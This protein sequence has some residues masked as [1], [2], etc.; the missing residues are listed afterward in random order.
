MVAEQLASQNTQIPRDEYEGDQAPESHEGEQINWTNYYDD[1][2]AE[3]WKYGTTSSG[4]QFQ[5]SQA[6]GFTRYQ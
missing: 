3:F 4:Q 1:V 5:W 6:D 2:S